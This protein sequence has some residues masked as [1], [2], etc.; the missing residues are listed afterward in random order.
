MRSLTWEAVV[1]GLPEEAA[2]STDA[3]EATP[4]IHVPSE[5]AYCSEGGEFF[6]AHL[7]IAGVGPTAAPRYY[8][9]ESDDFTGRR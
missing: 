7:V 6:H 3:S 1:R 5:H 9:I 4:P 2:G 8:V